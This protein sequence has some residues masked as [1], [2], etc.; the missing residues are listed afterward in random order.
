M[1]DEEFDNIGAGLLEMFGDKLPDPEHYPIHF[2][3]CVKLYRYDKMN[4]PSKVT[5]TETVTGT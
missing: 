1:T 4:Y 5:P 2:A 3:Y